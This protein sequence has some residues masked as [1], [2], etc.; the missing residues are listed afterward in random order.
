MVIHFIE[1]FRH[2]KKVEIWK[3]AVVFCEGSVVCLFLP[4]MFQFRNIAQMDNKCKRKL[5]QG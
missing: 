5:V 4:N 2:A 1:I 3:Y